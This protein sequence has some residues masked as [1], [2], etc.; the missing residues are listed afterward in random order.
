[1]FPVQLPT[2]SPHYPGEVAEMGFLLPFYRKGDRAGPLD[3]QW[4]QG[5]V[6]AS[7]QPSLAPLAQVLRF[8]FFSHFLGPQW[9]LYSRHTAHMAGAQ[10]NHRLH[11]QLC[12]AWQVPLL[13]WPGRRVP[14]PSNACSLVFHLLIRLFSLQTSILSKWICFGLF[15]LA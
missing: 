9:A 5:R 4:H 12:A 14:L 11:S 10:A 1:M 3:P 8:L 2:G 7:C 13:L 15:S 6:A